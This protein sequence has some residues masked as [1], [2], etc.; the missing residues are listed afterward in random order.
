MPVKN[1]ID[2]FK[3]YGVSDLSKKLQQKI[4]EGANPYEAARELIVAE[5]RRIHETAN[6]IRL[7]GKQKKIPYTE[8]KDIS[9]QLKKLKE[10][11]S[12]SV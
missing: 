2:C 6:E 1:P 12:V 10:K 11:P 4:E 5:H 3:N 8:P 7:I 9:Q